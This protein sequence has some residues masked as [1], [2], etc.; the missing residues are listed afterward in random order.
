[1]VCVL[2]IN[3]DHCSKQ[4]VGSTTETYG[5]WCSHKSGC[6]SGSTK[7]GLAAHLSHGCPGDTGREKDNLTV[8]LLDFM[9]VTMDEVNKAWHEGVGC[10]C[11]LYSFEGIINRRQ[12]YL[13]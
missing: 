3:D 9:D 6:N 7:T 11:T 2:D 4:Y 5:R 12:H 10:M 1:M 8:T 13:N